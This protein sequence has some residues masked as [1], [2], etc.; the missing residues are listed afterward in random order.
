MHLKD[1]HR[2]VIRYSLSDDSDADD[3]IQTFI[4]GEFE[5]IRRT[6]TL[7]R[8]LPSEWPARNC[9]NSIVE[10]SSSHF[11]YASTV[12][13]FIQSPKHRPD[14]RL[15]VILGLKQP[16]ERDR[17]YAR[18]DSLY[19]LIFLEIQDSVQLGNIYPAFGIMYLRSLKS[20]L[21]AWPQ[22]TSDLHTIDTLLELRPGDI[23][24]LF[25]PLLSLVTFEKDNIRILHKSL[26][27]YLLDPGRS[28]DFRLD[29]GLAHGEAAN[30]ILRHEKLR[31]HWG[32]FPI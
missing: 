29:V 20:G 6:H 2:K 31:D 23:T 21:L 30:Y 19:R 17:S 15:Q 28:G 1:D 5:R 8:H 10:R 18:L 13:R 26:F 32:E 9:I 27:D 12:I 22:W 16:Y 25:D 11:I 24:L 4:E 14:D 3:D 7:R